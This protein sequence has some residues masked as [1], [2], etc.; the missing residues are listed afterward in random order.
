MES[1]LT[2]KIEASESQMK[3]LTAEIKK[4]IEESLRLEYI[5]VDLE[6]LMK[7]MPYSRAFL[8]ENILS[9][10]RVKLCERRKGIR[11][12]RIWLYEPVKKAILDI[13]NNW[14]Y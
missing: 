8:E 13:I 2:V 9:H 14:E 7:I 1:A 11:G 12:K 4:D 3:Q 6:I 5:A 10:P